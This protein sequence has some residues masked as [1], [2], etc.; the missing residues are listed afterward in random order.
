M[1]DPIPL[2]DLVWQHAQIESDVLARITD[3][4]RHGSF[5]LGAEVREFELEFAAFTGM[6]H[7]VGVGSGTDALELAARAAGLQRGDEVLVPANSFIASCAS[8]MRAGL[9]PRL[10]DV[11]PEFLL[12]DP[13]R[14]EGAMTPLTRA[15]LPVHLY[16]QMA[17][18]DLIEP[19]CRDR[20]TRILE[21]AAQCHGA[22]RHGRCPGSY[23]LAAAVSF[24]PGKN[25]GAYGDAGAVLTDSPEIAQRVELFRNHGSED[26][27][28]HVVVG[29]NSRLDALQAVVL[30]AKLSRLVEWNA[31]RQAAAALYDDMLSGLEQVVRPAVMPGNV[32]VWHLYVVRV[33]HRDDVFA[34]MHTDGVGVGK[35]YPVPLHLQPALRDLGNGP[36]SFPIAERAATEILS[37]PLYPG[38]TEQQ[39]QRVVESL[40]SA[41]R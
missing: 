34:Q 41:L 18:V 2:V 16:G 9:V 7:C 22:T 12:V 23:S 4:M 29:F 32:H 39:Q 3:M 6:A 28:S 38:I 36:G 17:P 37:L 19:L 20:G 30:R 1:I 26:K 33:P 8:L 14:V 27:Y 21:D 11:D 31:M 15:V 35:H 10:V 24:Y 5:I 13:E 25:L 40:C